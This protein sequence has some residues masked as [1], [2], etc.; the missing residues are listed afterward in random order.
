MPLPFLTAF[1]REIRDQIYTY[2]LAS[3]SS[4][5]TL[6]PWTV[7]I[8]RSL[9]LLR[10]CKQVHR[11]CKDIIWAQ[12]GLSLREPCQLY[13]KFRELGK[14]NQFR[15]IHHVSISLELLDVD[16]LDWMCRAVKALGYWARE[17]R[18]K[19][20]AL[21]AVRERPR[22]VTEFKDVLDLR[23]RGESVDGRLYLHSTTSSTMAINTGWPPFSHWGK[24]RWLKEMLLDSSDPTDLLMEI[25]KEL[26]GDLFVDGML[27]FKDG[28]HI[29]K[30]F[31]LNPR[32]GEI[33]IIPRR[34][35]R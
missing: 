5:V 16:E 29:K 28:A 18:L 4:L 8:A 12:N 19:S 31:R 3:P 21:V 17:G 1:P 9:S 13:D 15:P 33:K 35:T 30:P 25:N 14:Q 27:Y 6:S 11:E 34:F 7:D 23:S 10:T 22:N 24:Q 2:V 32:D 20:I 26:G